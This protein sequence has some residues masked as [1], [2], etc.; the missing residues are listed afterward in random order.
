LPKRTRLRR[1]K[2]YAT[3]TG[4]PANEGLVPDLRRKNSDEGE[5][6]TEAGRRKPGALLHQPVDEL[7]IEVACGIDVGRRH[8]VEHGGGGART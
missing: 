3:V 4:G 8:M 6:V 5:V 2:G 7:R 1:S